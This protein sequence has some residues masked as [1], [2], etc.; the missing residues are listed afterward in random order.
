MLICAYKYKHG[1]NFKK[2]DEDQIDLDLPSPVLQLLRSRCALP[3]LAKYKSFN[4]VF[5]DVYCELS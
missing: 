3:V 2:K 5:F 1:H 4:K